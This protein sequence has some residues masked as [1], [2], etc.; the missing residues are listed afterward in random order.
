MC[1]QTCNCY[2]TF[3]WRF[4]IDE[5]I[6]S[7]RFLTSSASAVLPSRILWSTMNAW[8]SVRD[9]VCNR[10]MSAHSAANAIEYTPPLTARPV[11]NS[12]ENLGPLD[13]P[14]QHIPI[15][16]GLCRRHR[17]QVSLRMRSN[18]CVSIGEW[19]CVANK[20]IDDGM[21]LVLMQKRRHACITDDF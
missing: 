5:P 20:R 4:E 9:R 13:R 21:H 14:V 10:V 11:C 16:W 1:L 6:V 8:N 2:K 12:Q 17:C 7:R 18:W 15:F 19:P 3:M